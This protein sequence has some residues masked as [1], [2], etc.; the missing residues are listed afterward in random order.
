MT[1]K[2]LN[3]TYDAWSSSY[4]KTPNPLIPIEEIAIKSLLRSIE[5]HDVLDAAT[6][7]GRHAIYLAEMGKQVAAVDCNAN[8]LEEARKKASARNLSIDFR[9][10]DVRNLSFKDES[11]DLVICSL[12]LAHI[13]SLVEPC[14]ELIRVV[15]HNGYLVISDLHPFIQAQFGPEF[16]TGIVEGKGCL[17]FPNYHA[18]V[19]D[20]LKAV[21]ATGGEIITALDVPLKNKGKVFPGALIVWA[22]KP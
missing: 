22:R 18:E 5:F 20:Y 6:G 21:E 3:S 14:K 13:E 12:A 16:E 4:D 1:A 7:T 17:Y 15:R 10:D 9:Q 8:M 2:D 11:F 19:S